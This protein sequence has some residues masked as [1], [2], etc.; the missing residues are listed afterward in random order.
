MNGINQHIWMF[1]IPGMLANVSHMLV[2]KRNL[3]AMLS[4]PVSEPIF[5]RNKTWRG[6]LYLP[7][8]MGSL[9]TVSSLFRGPFLASHAAD[10]L[11]GLGM[12]L[13]YMIAELP[14]SFFKRRMGIGSGESSGSHPLLQLIIDKSDSLVGACLFY[15]LVTGTGLLEMLLLFSVCLVLHAFISWLLVLAKLKKS[16]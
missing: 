12:G 11:A 6:F 9:C 7:V 1:I 10:L 15:G 5:G 13:A 4:I 3:F 16:I 2:V 8:A 14:N